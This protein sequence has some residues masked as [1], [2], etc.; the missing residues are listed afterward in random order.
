MNFNRVEINNRMSFVSLILAF[1]FKD[2]PNNASIMFIVC[3]ILWRINYYI[4][5]SIYNKKLEE[6]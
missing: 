4:C 5:I 6:Q 1:I 3:A 2:V